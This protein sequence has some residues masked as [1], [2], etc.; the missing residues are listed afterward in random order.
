MYDWRR[1]G[2]TPYDMLL[3]RIGLDVA[4]CI[5]TRMEVVSTHIGEAARNWGQGATPARIASLGSGPA[6]EVQL[7]LESRAAV[8]TRAVFTLIDQEP[9]ALKYAA[10]ATFAQ[11]LKSNGT[12][13][14]HGLNISFTDILR[15]T[16]A[17]TQ[18]PPQHL[19]DS[20]G[21]LDYLERPP[22][23]CADPAPLRSSRAWRAPRRRQHER[24]PAQQPLADGI[25]GGPV[26]ALPGRSGDAGVDR[27][28]GAAPHLD[29]NR[30]TG[31]VRLLFA[32]KG[33]F[34]PRCAACAPP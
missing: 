29:R 33:W 14:V 16:G 12:I 13:A 18:L 11:V 3:H 6:R 20:V 27:R 2:A 19:V 30:R 17:L 25:R 21:L 28:P 9:A 10:E 7:F 22:L 26:A 23:P 31:R 32:E 1:V 34:K 5:R 15:S 24:V 8:G 4:E